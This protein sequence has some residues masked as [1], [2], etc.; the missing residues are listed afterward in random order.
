MG[1]TPVKQQVLRGGINM[2][3]QSNW[4]AGVEERGQ[5]LAIVSALG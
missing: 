3:F 1:S 5:R 2:S 4:K